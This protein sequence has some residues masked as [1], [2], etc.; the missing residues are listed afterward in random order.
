MKMFTII[1]SGFASV[2]LFALLVALCSWPVI[3]VYKRVRA[4]V[5][6]ARARKTALNRLRMLAI[7]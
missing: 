6:K 5:C 1:W 3:L 7:L 2:G 4:W